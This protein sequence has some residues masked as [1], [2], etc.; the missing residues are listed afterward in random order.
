MSEFNL[1]VLKKQFSYAKHNFAL[2][3]TFSFH[4][5]RM[6]SAGVCASTLMNDE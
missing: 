3:A 4:F 6:T 1:A 2:L 5:Y